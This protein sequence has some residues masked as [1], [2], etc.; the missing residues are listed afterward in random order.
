[1]PF[2]SCILHSQAVPSD[3]GACLI[4]SLAVPAGFEVFILSAT[5]LLMGLNLSLVTPFS[6]LPSLFIL[7]FFSASRLLL[8]KIHAVDFGTCSCFP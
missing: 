2:N 5:R 1:M 6:P 7:F 3:V 4:L 8:D